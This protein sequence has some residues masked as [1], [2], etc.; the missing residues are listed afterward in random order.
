MFS[1]DRRLQVPY[2]ERRGTSSTLISSL[3]WLSLNYF[4][5][6]LFGAREMTLKP[7]FWF[8]DRLLGKVSYSL[9]VLW[10]IRNGYLSTPSS[11]V[12]LCTSYQNPIT[13][14]CNWPFTS[15]YAIGLYSTQHIISLLWLRSQVCCFVQIKIKIA[16]FISNWIRSYWWISF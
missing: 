12:L 15:M 10:R 8:M 7:A 4:A 16:W 11:P 2:A 5:L 13:C 14:Y 3:P 9:K 6:I 1:S